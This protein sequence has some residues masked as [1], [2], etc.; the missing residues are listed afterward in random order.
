MLGMVK[1]FEEQAA[2]LIEQM[3]AAWTERLPEQLSALAHKLKGSAG[4]CG[5]SVMVSPLA[6]VEAA[7]RDGNLEE[8]G[9]QLAHVRTG[10]AVAHESLGEGLK[11][12]G[13]LQ[14]SKAT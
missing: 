13:K 14:I 9:R 1:L 12:N 5:I 10:L 8:A 3:E 2:Y 11:T 7:A 6:A 4:T